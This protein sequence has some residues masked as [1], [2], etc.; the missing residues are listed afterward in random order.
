MTKYG[1]GIKSLALLTTAELTLDSRTIASGHMIVFLT[2]G[3]ARGLGG[4]G[5]SSL[6]F[7][8]RSVEIMQYRAVWINLTVSYVELVLN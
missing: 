2:P 1:I 3:Y 8:C 5:V 4:D 6:S 7:L